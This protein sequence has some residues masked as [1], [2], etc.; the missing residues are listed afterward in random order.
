MSG[1]YIDKNKDKDFGIFTSRDLDIT[2]V[3]FVVL[4]ISS[5]IALFVI[6]DMIYVCCCFKTDEEI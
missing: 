6:K 1:Y 4:S 5:I 2:V 3:L